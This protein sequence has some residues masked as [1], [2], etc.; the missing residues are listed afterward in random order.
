MPVKPS[1]IVLATIGSLGDLHPMMALGLELQRRGHESIVVTTEYYRRKIEQAG[2]AFRPLRPEHSL[3]D[4]ML[5]RNVLDPKKGPEFIIRT[6]LLPKLRETY[7]DLAAL[8]EGA[9]FLIA[10]EIVYAAPL[11]AERQNLRWAAAILSPCSFFS[12]HDPSVIAPAPFTK[13]LLGAP[14]LLQRAL[15]ALGK[16]A[17]RSWGAPIH[18]LRAALGLRRIKHPFFQDKFSPHLNLALFS[19]E[20]ARPQPDW[21]AKTIQTGFV[22]YDQEQHGTGLPPGLKNFLDSGEPPIVFTLGSTAV[23]GA[24]GFYEQSA[25]AARIL[26]R[27]A[28]LL[29]GKNQRPV[30]SNNVVAFDY[31]PYSQVFP[32]AA[33]IVHQGGI[34]TTAQ[35]L[36]AGRPQLV[37]PFGFDQPDNAARVERLGVAGVISRSKYVTEHVASQLQH[38]LQSPVYAQRAAEVGCR[39]QAEDGLRRACE[40]IEGAISS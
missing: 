3:E 26:G 2:L 18:E 5:L 20:L 4:P 25:E 36:R 7:E 1:R 10:G 28:V 34:G 31:A 16:L 24:G 32:R 12:P 23:M 17:A 33:C 8:A 40:A 27:R 39:L 22:F 37:M 15:L 6:L 38:L 14:L 19:P 13:K 35:A 11:V 29:L 30:A 9:D 21:P